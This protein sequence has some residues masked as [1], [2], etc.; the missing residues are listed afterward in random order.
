[1]DLFPN[2]ASG[3][4]TIDRIT[5][6]SAITNLGLIDA[7]GRTIRTVPW[8]GRRALELELGDIPA[9]VLLLRAEDASGR[10]IATARLIVGLN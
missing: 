9:Q 1:M 4:V 10:P 3:R 8:T 7:M 2:P 6:G 5:N